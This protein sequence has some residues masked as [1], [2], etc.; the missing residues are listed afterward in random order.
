MAIK[1]KQATNEKDW[2]VTIEN[3]ESIISKNH[4]DLL[5]NATVMDILIKTDGKKAAYSWSGGKDS[6]VLGYVCELAEIKD[7]IFAYC[8]LEYKQF[9]DWIKANK[10]SG[11]EMVN[12]GQDLEWLSKH[13]EML[14]PQESKT[15]AKW[16]KIV[17]HKGQEI[18]YRKHQL[19][20]LLLGRRKADGNYV[21]KGSNIYTNSK[22]ITRYSPLADWTHEEILA[23]I[24]YYD[25]PI[26]PI[27]NWKN[28]YICGTHNWAARQWTGNEANGWKEVYEIEPDIVHE[29]SRYFVGAKE[30]LDG[31]TEKKL[32]S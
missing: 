24:H 7:C 14:F 1:K 12:T 8:D 4:I 6:I 27:Y 26:P 17:Q 28:G 20:M 29:A 2:L 25:L 22:G 10:P 11:C 15:A 9:M 23:C 16:F 30:F 19:D 21:G 32:N 31:K 3:I 18:Y 13:K 5:I